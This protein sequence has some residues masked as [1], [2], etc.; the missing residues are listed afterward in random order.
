M[1]NAFIG[2][3]L[4]CL[5]TTVACSND[6]DKYNSEPPMFSDFTIQSVATGSSEVQAGEKFVIRGVQKSSG[7]LLYFS[8]S[9]GQLVDP[10]TW[11]VSPDAASY[12]KHRVATDNSGKILYYAEPVDTMVIDQA[13]TYTIT[14]TGKYQAGGNTSAWSSAHGASFTEYW[15][16]KSSGSV[17]YKTNGLLSFTV[18]AQKKIT[19]H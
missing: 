9:N 2:S 16:D 8:M 3:L 7:N 19:I 17:Q 14:F 12:N 15:A 11:S 13:G 6:D 10:F 1:K 4:L 18:T 5:L